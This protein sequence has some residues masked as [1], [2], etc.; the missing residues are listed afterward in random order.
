VELANHD[1]HFSPR[2]DVYDSELRILDWGRKTAL[3]GNSLTIYGAAAPNSTIYVAVSATDN[4]SG[5][6]V[7]TV[8]PMKAYD[9]YEPNDD[10]FHAYK[11]QPQTTPDGKLEYAPFKANIMDR[12]D[13][14]FYSFLATR[15]G[16]VTVEVHNESVALIPA[17]QLYGADMRSMGFG[18]TLRDPG[19]SLVTSMDVEKGQTYYIQVWSQANTSGPYS[20]WVH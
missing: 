5:K 12:D 9:A 20:L 6:Y 15:A 18:P 16:K 14:D 13:T 1:Y 2:V 19:E 10:I 7:L 3:A 4:S 8:K 11:I 17:V